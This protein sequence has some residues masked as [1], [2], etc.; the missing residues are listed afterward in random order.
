VWAEPF[1]Y[2]ELKRLG[3]T[4]QEVRELEQ[5][6]MDAIRLHER[7][8]AEAAHAAMLEKLDALSWRCYAELLP[9]HSPGRRPGL[10]RELG[11]G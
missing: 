1:D 10:R 5:S 9:H 3:F 2:V 6:R 7:E 11:A 4:L 8:A